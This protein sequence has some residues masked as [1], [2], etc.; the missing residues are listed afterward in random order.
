MD[1]MRVLYVAVSE[2]RRQIERGIEDDESPKETGPTVGV[3]QMVTPVF[4]NDYELH[5]HIL[6]MARNYSVSV[7]NELG[8]EGVVAV[9]A[10][11]EMEVGPKGSTQ[12]RDGYGVLVLSPGM[13]IARLVQFDGSIEDRNPAGEWVSLCLSEISPTCGYVM[14]W[15]KF[16]LSYQY[17]VYND[18]DEMIQGILTRV[19]QW[20]GAMT[21]VNVDRLE[22]RS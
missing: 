2:V 13:C 12:I 7:A 1:W 14:D 6:N 17:T 9:A 8:G 11:V 22:D 16:N 4:L 18:K 5:R 15:S 21:F 3:G 19:S 10:R 20:E